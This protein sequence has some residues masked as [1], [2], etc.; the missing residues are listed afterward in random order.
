[1]P[2][3]AA[4]LDS[5]DLSEILI[6]KLLAGQASTNAVALQAAPLV[7]AVLF[8]TLIDKPTVAPQLAEVKANVASSVT[9]TCRLCAGLKPAVAQVSADLFETLI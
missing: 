9:M 1:V 2:K 5:A 7:N 3:Q 8:K 6:S 4:A